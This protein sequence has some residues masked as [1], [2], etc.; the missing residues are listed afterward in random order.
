MEVHQHLLKFISIKIM[1]MIIIMI[2]LL[3]LERGIGL[4]LVKIGWGRR[5]IRRL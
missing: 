2:I 4:K 1:A 5:K 3:E